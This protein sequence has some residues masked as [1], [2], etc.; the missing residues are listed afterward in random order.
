MG[1]AHSD[2]YDKPS[3]HEA[4]KKLQGAIRPLGLTLSEV[5]MRWLI[6][7][8]ALGEGDGFIVGGSKL[9]QIEGFLTNVEKGAL[10]ENVLKVV[11]EV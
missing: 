7:H 5:A 9:E 1:A 3:M 8:S 10:P 2:W 6:Y 4:A 11:Y